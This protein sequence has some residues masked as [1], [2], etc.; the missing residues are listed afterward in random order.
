MVDEPAAERGRK[1]ERRAA[2]EARGHRDSVAVRRRN[3]LGERGRQVG[4]EEE[5]RDE[6]DESDDERLG[7]IPLRDRQDARK[8]VEHP[9]ERGERQELVAG[10]EDREE[11]DDRDEQM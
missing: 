4:D 5:P 2:L 7:H 10:K 3:R 8:E 6:R 11:Q 1:I 9:R